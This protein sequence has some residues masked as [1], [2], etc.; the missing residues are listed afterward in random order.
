MTKKE[1]LFRIIPAIIITNCVGYLLKILNLDDYFILLGFRFK[2]NFILPALFF[3]KAEYFT[4]VKEIIKSSCK[5][6]FSLQLFIVIFPFLA[7]LGALYYYGK[8]DLGDPDYFYEF[9]LSSIFDAPIYLLWNL[10]QLLAL[11]LLIRYIADQ[12]DHKFICSFITIALL[13]AYD[14]VPLKIYSISYATFILPLLIVASAAVALAYFKNVFS[15][16]FIV[17]GMIWAYYLMFGTASKAIVNILFAARYN[18][19]EG[20]LW[21]DD[22]LIGYVSLVYFSASFLLIWLASPMYKNVKPEAE[23]DVKSE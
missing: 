14:M 18:S 16:S 22:K 2:L 7:A 10:P 20:L 15:A 21:V 9:G 12:V 11:T 3:L 13:F 6:R 23:E 19:W 17:F 5:T 4:G 1:I 8:V